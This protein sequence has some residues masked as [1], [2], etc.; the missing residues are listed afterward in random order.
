MGGFLPAGASERAEMLREIGCG[1][2][3]ELFSPIPQEVRLKGLDIPQGMSELQAQRALRA[4]AKKN[5]VFDTIFRGAGAYRHYIPAVV[6]SV[7]GK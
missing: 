1:S 3:D 6:G 4:M 7:T 5:K 2:I